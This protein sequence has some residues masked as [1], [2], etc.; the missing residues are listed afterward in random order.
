MSFVRVSVRLGKTKAGCFG[1]LEQVGTKTLNVRETI[2]F[3]S[4]RDVWAAANIK[5]MLL[6]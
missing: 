2:E 3:C 6:V 1:L 4:G 5:D